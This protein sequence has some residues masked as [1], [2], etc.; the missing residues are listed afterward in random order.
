M[1][2]GILGAGN[3]A[4]VMANTIAKMDG[5]HVQAIA[6]RDKEKA[7]KFAEEFQIAE[8]YGTYEELLQQ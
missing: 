7:K 6:S 2:V 3:I 5:V 8:W 1:N 4:G